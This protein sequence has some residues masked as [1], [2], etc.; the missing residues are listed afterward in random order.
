MYART[1]TPQMSQERREF[2]TSLYRRG[3]GR[4]QQRWRLVLAVAADGKE[5]LQLRGDLVGGR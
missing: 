5:V 3:D 2:T 1:A 4:L